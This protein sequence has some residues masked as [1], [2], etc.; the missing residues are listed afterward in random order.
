MVVEVDVKF[1]IRKMSGRSGTGGTDDEPDSG[2][3]TIDGAREKGAETTAFSFC[4]CEGRFPVTERVIR[5]AIGDG[6]APE[7]RD[8]DVPWMKALLIT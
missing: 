6:R 8:R 7:G 4:F 2:S 5:R 3:V 1:V